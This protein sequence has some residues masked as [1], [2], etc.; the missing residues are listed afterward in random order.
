MEHP[1]DDISP[2]RPFVANSYQELL[3]GVA[4]IL[5][6]AQGLIQPAEAS[7]KEVLYSTKTVQRLLG[8]KG[9]KVTSHP[10]LNKVLER[11]DIN[12]IK[13]GKINYYNTSEIDAIPTI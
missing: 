5:K 13:K 11:Y 12:P 10:G 8:E 4:K 2:S 7:P 1:F 9:Y 3:L 6:D